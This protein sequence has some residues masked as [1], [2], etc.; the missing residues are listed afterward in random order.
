MSPDPKGRN[1]FD[2]QP[3][4]IGFTVATAQHVLG[5]PGMDRE[6]TDRDIRM[7]KLE[8]NARALLSQLDDMNESELG[9][10]LKLEVLAETHDTRVD[11]VVR[12]SHGGYFKGFHDLIPYTFYIK[13]AE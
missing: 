8:N 1:I 11:Q 2:S 3:A 6:S 13:H 9:D 12:A 7:P 5:R 10:F 4:R